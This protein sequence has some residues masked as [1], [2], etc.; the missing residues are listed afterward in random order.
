M[1][2]CQDIQGILGDVLRGRADAAAAARVERHL[3]DCPACRLEAGSERALSER[4]RG[5]AVPP[6][7]SSLAAALDRIARPAAEPAAAPR[8]AATRLSWLRPR[9]SLAA[10]GLLL[11]AGLAFF[12]SLPGAPVPAA[13]AAAAEA[14]QEYLD[15]KIVA[16]P[17]PP[18]VLE[19]FERK[20]AGSPKPGVRPM[21]KAGFSCA[22][23]C[24]CAC[25][26]G[27]G[28]TS[29][30]VFYRRAGDSVGLVSIPAKDVLLDSS[31]QRRAG[32]LGYHAFRTGGKTV[33]ACE[34]GPDLHVWVSTLPEPDL[35]AIV[36][37]T[38]GAD[39]A[40]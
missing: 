40:P 24:T 4:L 33:L 38:R 10:A 29:R 25:G 27:C 20:L 19:A 36:R 1:E 30:M 11:A 39:R 8:P 23:T 17:A 5:I 3:A 28:E 7:P 13:L 2:A 12:L 22:G 21:E 31:T 37:K 6:A 16:A 15:G 35:L 18:D 14:Y 26:C 32:E 9:L 34:C